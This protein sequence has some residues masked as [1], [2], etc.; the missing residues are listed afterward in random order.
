MK[1]TCFYQEDNGTIWLGYS[2][3][4]VRFDYESG[5]YE[6]I[7]LGKYISSP[8]FDVKKDSNG[9]FWLG[10][11][12]DG[13]LYCSNSLEIMG[14]F[15]A[16]GSASH[17][18][19]SNVIAALYIDD[20]DLVWI[21]T[22]P[23][24]MDVLVPNLKPFRK[25]TSDFFDPAVFS[26]VGVRFFLETD[27]GNIWVGTQ[28]DGLVVFD[29]ITDK[30]VRRIIPGE[31]GFVPNTA[32][33]L[34]QDVQSR[35][36]VGTYDGLY[37]SE[38]NG[39]HFRKIVNN[40]RPQSMVSSNFI[41]HILESPDGTLIF[42][43]EEGIYFL[44]PN[45]TDPQ[46]IDTLNNIISGRLHLMGDNYLLISEA[47]NGFHV[48]KTTDWFERREDKNKG[49]RFIKHFLPHFNIK[50]FYQ[51]ENTDILWLA[52]NAG[53]I[54][55][56][57]SNDWSQLE[58]LKQYTR[59]NGLPSNYIYGVLPDKNGRLW[60]STNRG[61]S[62]FD[63]IA[64][65]FFN[66]SIEDGLQGFEFNTNS[67]MKKADGEFYFGGTN[68]FNRFYPEFKQNNIAPTIQITDFKINDK[69]FAE[70]NY[71]GEMDEV[72]LAYDENT[73]SIQF[74]AIDY[75]SNGNNKYRAI[76]ENYLGTW[77]ELGQSNTIRY[78]KVPPGNYLFKVAAANSDGVWSEEAKELRIYIAPPWYQTWWAVS[79]WVALFFSAVLFIYKYQLS[80]K[81]TEREAHRLKELDGFKTR[82]YANIT[83]EFRTPLT[84]IS[85]MA[86]ALKSNP[87]QERE[88][89]LNLIKKNSQ[90]LLALVNRMLDLSKLQAGKMSSDISQGDV[91][92]L[93]KYL[94][95]A[96]ESFAK[97]KNV[98]LQFYSEEKELL[99]DF[100][101]KKM[102]QVLNNL[103]SNAIKF[104]TE[105][106]K[107]LVVA[108]RHISN[109]KPWL[110]IKI[111][112]TGIGISEEQLPHIFDRF[113]QANPAHENQGSGIGLA[114]VKELMDNM[115][116]K[117][118]VDSSLHAG[119][120][121]TLLFP[122]T[123]HAPFSEMKPVKELA[124]PPVLSPEMA[125][126]KELLDDGLPIL[127]IIEDSP[128]VTY[129]LK[130]T[131]ENDYQIVTARNGRQGVEKA[132]DILPDLII[133]DVMMP[134][135]DGFEVCEKLKTDERTNHI[136]VILLTAK[137]TADD[138][139]AGLSH[140]ADA[141]LVKPFEKAELMVR[142][143]KLMELRRTLQKKYSTALV[144][145]NIENIK[146]PAPE[147]IFLQKLEAIVLAHHENE[148]FSIHELSRELLL[149]RSQ[150]H[151]KIKALTG[152]STAIYIRHV[153]LEKAKELL[154]TTH[155][156]ISEIAYQTGF[157]TPVYFSQIFKEVV[158]AS[159]TE[160]RE[161][162]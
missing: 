9:N 120:T 38:N 107:I 12:H 101:A 37:L 123:N 45:L 10:T 110:E 138:K 16:E 98:G 34:L 147:E 54:K 103:V 70:N 129:Y 158:G 159:P 62:C 65:L 26:T 18:L 152:L 59:D 81:T 87:E 41:G 95:E 105:Y 112:D 24:G 7:D 90:S 117:I 60:M 17:R 42:A 140:G 49:Q 96:H 83:H 69:Y 156:S 80:K 61:I 137:A 113:H 77:T 5:Q 22:D 74:A 121:F 149:S 27:D 155:L 3:G 109:S 115:D 39:G 111:K 133:S 40:S 139:L 1:L 145:S 161:K 135:M 2:N 136:P 28:E 20:D 131:L 19:S 15:R 160:W 47:H 14:H 142:L 64:E 52:T 29:P 86:D 89:K 79:L 106:G 56:H 125:D 55:A 153:R 63:P 146:A 67:F 58:I 75:Q 127:L 8:V 154:R 92:V 35:I 126:E 102:E 119:T 78:T 141:Y 108:K 11:S 25:Y 150:A 97:T 71:I 82:F 134:E 36:W 44:P 130:S 30:A 85:G 66:Y 91:I 128:D 57:F 122:I 73:F 132:L 143:Q 148:D 72:H 68:G 46:P 6:K 4:V 21:N 31:N 33:C 50:H 116:G 100:D 13:L 151:R 157:K 23:E 162:G 118:R 84:V 114:L 93:L 124:A 76:L 99:M 51:P 94:T 32:T 88:K 43:T 53:L 104:T 48:L 144:G